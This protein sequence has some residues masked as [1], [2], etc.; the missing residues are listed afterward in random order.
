VFT[1]FDCGHI[2]GLIARDEY[3]RWYNNGGVI[4]CQQEA[5]LVEFVNNL[6]RDEAIQRIREIG[7]LPYLPK[8]FPSLILQYQYSKLQIKLADISLDLLGGTEKA[9]YIG[10]CVKHDQTN[11][12]TLQE[13]YNVV[14]QLQRHVV[15]ATASGFLDE[16][17][18]K[19][20]RAKMSAIQP[21][22]RDACE[23][24]GEPKQYLVWNSQT[25]W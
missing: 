10:K 8:L 6:S 14:L 16:V 1:E 11:R 4:D 12:W 19:R 23:E 21:G 5:T 9:E 7:E 2:P 3:Q 13:I 22:F 24:L 20:L 17:S 15:Q 18:L 25:W